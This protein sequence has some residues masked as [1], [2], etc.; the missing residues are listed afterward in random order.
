[1]SINLSAL[2]SISGLPIFTRA[3]DSTGKC[4]KISFISVSTLNALNLFCNAN[5]GELYSASSEKH[6]IYWK[7]IDSLT[8]IIFINQTNRPKVS[9]T[10]ESLE[11]ILTLIYNLILMFVSKNELN[12][13]QVDKIKLKIKNCYF[14]IDYLIECYLNKTN[15]TLESSCLEIKLGSYKCAQLTDELINNLSNAGNSNTMNLIY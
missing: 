12:K 9:F 3:Y 7:C 15:L 11:K 4:E 13:E 14:V 8:L 1:M 5:Q 6:K 10:D 2:T